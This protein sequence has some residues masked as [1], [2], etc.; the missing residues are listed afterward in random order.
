MRRPAQPG[1]HLVKCCSPTLYNN[2]VTLHIDCLSEAVNQMGCNITADHAWL[3]LSQMEEG[4]SGSPKHTGWLHTGC[5]GRMQKGNTSSHDVYFTSII[6]C[7]RFW[8][9][10]LAQEVLK[11]QLDSII[12]Y[13]NQR[14]NLQQTSDDKMQDTNNRGLQSAS[15]HT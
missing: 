1:S 9:H 12:S 7:Y 3:G 13:N 15:F 6:H 2:P 5:K 4:C 14:Q 8:G 10:L 11:R